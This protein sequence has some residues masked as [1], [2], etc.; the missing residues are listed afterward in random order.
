MAKNRKIEQQIAVF[1]ESGS[2]KTVLVSSFYGA[3]QQQA[4]LAVTVHAKAAAV[5]IHS[6][7]GEG[8]D[9]HGHVAAISPSRH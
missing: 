1:G 4:Y 8:G 6:A 7:A 9:I 3:T 5:T 2:G